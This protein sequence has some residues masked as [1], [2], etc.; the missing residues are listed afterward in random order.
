M[1]DFPE[2]NGYSL[3]YS[4]YKRYD[5]FRWIIRVLVLKDQNLLVFFGALKKAGATL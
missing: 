4:D 3:A 2:A 1:D 5:S